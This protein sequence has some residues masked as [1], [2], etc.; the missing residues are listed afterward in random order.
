MSSDF[1]TT[2]T[3]NK[4]SKQTIR[5]QPGGHQT[6]D[7]NNDCRT[8]TRDKAIAQVA[9][10]T[11]PTGQHKQCSSSNKSLPTPSTSQPTTFGKHYPKHRYQHHTNPAHLAR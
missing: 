3:Q 4:Q 8:D 2:T 9:T 6:S 11:N 7:G 1:T 5:R 10:N